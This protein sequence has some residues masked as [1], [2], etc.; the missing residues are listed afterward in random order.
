MFGLSKTAPQIAIPF[1]AGDP[2]SFDTYIGQSALKRR[3]VLRLESMKR[4]E[5][6]KALFFA[7]FGQGKTSLVRVLAR[8]LFERKLIDNYCETV[9]GRFE[10]KVDLDRFLQSI[11]PYTL[12][13]IDEIHGLGGA[14]RDALYP[15]IQDNVYPFQ[16]GTNMV[17]LPEGLSWIGAT[18]ELGR[19]HPA[20]QRRLIPIMLEPLNVFERAVIAGTQTMVVNE[21]AAFEIAN[22]CWSPWEVKDEI[23]VTASDVAKSKKSEIITLAHVI[24]SCDVLGIDKNSL[25]PH[26]RRV[27]ETLRKNPKTL[28]RGRV[29]SMAKN[30]LVTISGVDAET[31]SSSVEP[32]LLRLG[33]IS[34]SSTGRELTAKA[35]EEYFKETG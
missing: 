16:D 15:A 31:F 17:R 22:R 12:I 28:R 4:G 24:E 3:M 14:V 27:L 6:L 32:K 26:E 23:Y 11:K 10:T 19:V 9:A 25:R 20:L 34:V 5:S 30:P 8:E 7:P 1:K 29:Y 33:Y 13:F 35:L 21:E 2:Y 18:T